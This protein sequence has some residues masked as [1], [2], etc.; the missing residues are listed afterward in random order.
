MASTKKENAKIL[1]E[2]HRLR[3]PG[4]YIDTRILHDALP[5][6]V[7]K[8]F[9]Q[10]TVI[11]RLADKGLLPCEKKKK[12]DPTEATKKR[13]LVFAEKHQDKN[14]QQW[15]AHLQAVG[16]LKDRPSELMVLIFSIF[17]Y[18]FPLSAFG[19]S[20]HDYSWVNIVLNNMMIQHLETSTHTFWSRCVI[21]LVPIRCCSNDR[22]GAQTEG[23]D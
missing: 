19:G 16:D 4:R 7:R 11:R 21:G 15:Q 1:K 9:G 17:N 20:R 14:F 6:K 23:A 8:K 3:P 10:R 12:T 5:E 22:A 2:F 18:H 13:R